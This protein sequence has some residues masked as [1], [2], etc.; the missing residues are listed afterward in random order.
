MDPRTY[1]QQTIKDLRS[2]DAKRFSGIEDHQ[3]VVVLSF[4][5]QQTATERD[6]LTQL[7]LLAES[8]ERSRRTSLAAAARA[9]LED[10]QSRVSSG[11]SAASPA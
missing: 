10:W 11:S 5:A 7:K 3:I 1:C 2:S 6:F 4:F 8:A 9:V